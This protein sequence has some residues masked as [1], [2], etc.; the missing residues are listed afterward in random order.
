M[1]GTSGNE[2]DFL[3]MV[4]CAVLIAKY[5]IPARPES[6][7]RPKSWN[8]AKTNAGVGSFRFLEKPR[9]NV[10]YALRAFAH[11]DENARDAP[12]RP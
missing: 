12:D 5:Q 1:S 11:T 2:P 10:A 6:G 3:M 9:L 8:G 7:P 4:S